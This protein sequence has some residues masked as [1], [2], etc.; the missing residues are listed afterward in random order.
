MPY[1]NAGDGNY[2]AGGLFSFV[3]KA[4]GGLAK[5]VIGATPFGGIVNTVAPILGRL[6]RPKQP[7]MPAC[8]RPML[9][10]RR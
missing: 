5:K 7:K 6:R 4:L 9:Y 8:P 2:A 3:G 1:Y 10:R